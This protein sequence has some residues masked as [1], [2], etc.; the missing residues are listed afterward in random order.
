MDDRSDATLLAAWNAGDSGAFTALVDRHQSALL[1][2]AQ[3]FLGPGPDREDVVQDAFLKLARK[4]PVLP[5]E[6]LG[7]AD[8]ERAALAGWLHKVTRNLCLDAMRSET[9]RKKREQQVAVTE[10]TRGGIDAVETSDTRAAVERGLQRLPSDQR[11]VLVL[12]LFGERSYQEIAEITGKKAGT[13]GWILSVGMK[14]LASELAPLLGST[15]SEREARLH[16]GEQV[17]G[18]QGGAS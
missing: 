12:R 2:H 3:A 7:D 10:A 11:E 13:V 16:A 1:H 14:R 5:D 18:L 6:V 17:P 8:A 9:R 15:D 4:P